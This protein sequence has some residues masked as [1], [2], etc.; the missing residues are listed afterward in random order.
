[1]SNTVSE[2]AFIHCLMM[3]GELLPKRSPDKNQRFVMIKAFIM[4][5]T[6]SETA[7]IHCLMMGGELLPKRSPN[8]NQRLIVISLSCLIQCQ[9]QP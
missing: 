9:K 7:F 1:M 5:N 4:S 3:G 8:K 2:T 6:V